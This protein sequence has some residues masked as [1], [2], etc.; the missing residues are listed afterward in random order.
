MMMLK[1]LV[2]TGF[3]LFLQ[4]NIVANSAALANSSAGPIVS[5]HMQVN[6]ITLTDSSPIQADN[7]PKLAQTF[8][9]IETSTTQTATLAA[10]T[11]SSSAKSDLHQLFDDYSRFN[12]NPD[13]FTEVE[14]TTLS[15][16]ENEGPV[17]Q[18]VSIEALQ[19]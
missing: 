7:S 14:D 17:F 12:G 19:R 8:V 2:L 18:D 15:E 5:S 10:P 16:T 11:D 4:L 3:I 1:K 9:Q 6:T 13:G